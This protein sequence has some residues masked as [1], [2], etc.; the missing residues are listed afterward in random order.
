MENNLKC[1]SPSLIM[2]PFSVMVGD[3]TGVGSC[4]TLA[5]ACKVAAQYPHG[6]VMDRYYNTFNVDGTLREAGPFGMPK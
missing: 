5:K 6:Y 1:D 2:A 4:G 3:G